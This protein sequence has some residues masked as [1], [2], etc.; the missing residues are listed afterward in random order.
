MERR[1]AEAAE[2][3]S[4]SVLIR[5]VADLPEDQRTVQRMLAQQKLE[6][7]RVYMPFDLE[8]PDFSLKPFIDPRDDEVRAGYRNFRIYCELRDALAAL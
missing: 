7:N 6:K 2:L 1:A 3:A 8:P 4:L 5:H